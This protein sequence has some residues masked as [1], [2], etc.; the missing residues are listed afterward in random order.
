[1]TDI[2]IVSLFAYRKQKR[3]SKSNTDRN[4]RLVFCQIH[5]YI[6]QHLLSIGLWCMC[7]LFLFFFKFYCNMTIK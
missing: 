6:Y 2:D 1:M 4:G 3:H 7:A 5:I